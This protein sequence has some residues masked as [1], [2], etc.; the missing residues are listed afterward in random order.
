M[1]LFA[2]DHAI[3]PVDAGV[4]RVAMRLGYGRPGKV[5]SVRSVRRVLGSL[6]RGDLGACRRAFVYLSHHAS[7]TC[8]EREPHCRVCPLAPEC[9]EALGALQRNRQ[10]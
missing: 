7:L 2:G 9:P 8:T 1:L 3:V 10:S 4:R 6:L 5:L